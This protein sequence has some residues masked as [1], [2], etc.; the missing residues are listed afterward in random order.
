MLPGPDGGLLPHTPPRLP[1][2]CPPLLG[3]A[4]WTSTRSARP[5]ILRRPGHPQCTWVE[6]G[7]LRPQRLQG[8][9]RRSSGVAPGS[10]APHSTCDQ[11]ALAAR[12]RHHSLPCETNS[13][14]APRPRPPLSG[15]WKGPSAV[16]FTH[17][18]C[19]LHTRTRWLLPPP[20]TPE[21][22]NPRMQRILTLDSDSGACVSCLLCC[23]QS[24]LSTQHPLPLHLRPPCRQ[25]PPR[26]LAPSP[27]PRCPT[28]CSS[29]RT[30]H[31]CLTCTCCFPKPGLEQP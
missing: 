31:T 29:L 22:P 10:L 20:G 26:A 6:R 15:L 16:A 8:L 14:T 17:S 12:Q 4:P 21:A 9:L 13:T 3:S 5:A 1:A 24:C 18:R 25:V 7:S 19:L 27:W 28:C 2:L 23:P 30:F 11:S